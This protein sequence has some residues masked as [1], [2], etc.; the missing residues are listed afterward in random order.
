LHCPKAKPQ[1]SEIERR[2][3]RWHE[4][5]F[6]LDFLAIFCHLMG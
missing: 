6:T 2:G 3:V 4:V 1:V 5:T